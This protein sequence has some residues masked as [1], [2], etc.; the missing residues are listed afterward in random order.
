MPQTYLPNTDWDALAKNVKDF[1]HRIMLFRLLGKLGLSEFDD[2]IKKLM[3]GWVV[4]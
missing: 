4:R 3:V 2:V 1:S